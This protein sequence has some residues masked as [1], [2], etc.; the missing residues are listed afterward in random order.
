[1]T[2]GISRSAESFAAKAGLLSTVLL[3][4][5]CEGDPP[6]PTTQDLVHPIAN[7]RPSEGL[8]AKQVS[9]A[10]NDMV[11]KTF[12]GR[13]VGEIGVL[14]GSPDYMF[15]DITDAEIADSGELLVLDAKF[16]EVRLY[17]AD[18]KLVTKAGKLGAGP[19][20]FRAARSVAFDSAG[21]IYVGDTD[22]SIDRFR[23]A[24]NNVLTYDTSFTV[25]VDARD[26]CR[27]GDRLYV[28]GSSMKM[29]GLIQVFGE[30]GRRV[31]VFGKLYKSGSPGIDFQANEG[32]IA[33]SAELGLLAYARTSLVGEVRV[34]SSDGRPLWRT[35]IAGYQPITVTSHSNGGLSVRMP[36]KGFHRLESLEFKP[37]D[38]VVLQIALVTAAS[39]E[40]KSQ[41]ESI[42][43]LVFDARKGTL[44]GEWAIAERIVAISSTTLVTSTLDPFPMIRTRRF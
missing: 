23:R 16:S 32:R 31:G 6:P 13:P 18:G 28:H 24:A 36:E 44:V 12:P 15:A 17:S 43:T 38:L 19:G 8:R 25:G 14:E 27:I 40:S 33:C 26:L 3:I 10:A 37:P 4:V 29:D 34:Y 42:N 41:F 20:E 21:R 39:I 7:F 22:H 11:K 35:E 9:L 2:M 30:D 1:M 5:G